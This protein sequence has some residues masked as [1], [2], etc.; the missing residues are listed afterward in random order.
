MAKLNFPLSAFNLHAGLTEDCG[1][2]FKKPFRSAIR[3]A[4]LNLEE[5]IRA[6]I[7]SDEDGHNLITEAKNK[8]VF[9][10]NKS[11]EST[12]L[13]FLYSGA[14]MWLRN[15]PNHRKLKYGKEEALKIIV[16]TDYLIQ[17]FDQ[18][19]SENNI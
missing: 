7:G 17:L 18:L 10:R 19:C 13:Y 2:V 4:L 1:P 12:G 16:F 3:E 11:S 14:I 9:K 8:G 6:K 15:P 5:K